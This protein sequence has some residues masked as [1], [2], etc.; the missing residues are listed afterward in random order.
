MANFPTYDQLSKIP[1]TISG[2][3]ILTYQSQTVLVNN[4][5]NT[6]ANITLPPLIDGPPGFNLRIIKIASNSLNNV[7][8]TAYPGDSIEVGGTFIILTPYTYYHFIHIGNVWLYA[9]TAG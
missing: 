2:T 8:I 9:G 3:Q 5:A 1:L 4:P 6:A 7:N